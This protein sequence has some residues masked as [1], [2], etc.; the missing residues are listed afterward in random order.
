MDMDD[1]L[2]ETDDKMT[3]SLEFL[4]QQFAGLRTGKASTSLVEN[5]SVS[6]YGSTVRLR[7]LANITTPEARLV[8]INA[9]DPSALGA[10]EKAVIA[11]NLGVTPLND[12]RVI[13]IPIPELSEERRREMIKVAKQMTEKAR[14][15]V[16]S[17]RQEA[18]ER[19]K[20]LQKESTITE[21]D[22]KRGLDEIQKQTD[23]CIAR[24]DQLLEAKEQ[25]MLTF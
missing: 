14:V 9:Y 1:V 4:R 21:D 3:K 17:V 19:V 6:Y 8:I 13:R 5:L 22:K 11:A 24:M 12:G 20:A 16:R 23:A 2:L 18:N 25:E 7:E 10:I 15:A